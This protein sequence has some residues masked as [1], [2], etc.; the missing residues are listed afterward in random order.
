M[1]PSYQKGVQ[2]LEETASEAAFR[3]A[4]NFQDVESSLDSSF[5]SLHNIVPSPTQTPLTP[6]GSVPRQSKLSDGLTGLKK[7]LPPKAGQLIDN[8]GSYFGRSNP[9]AQAATPSK[10]SVWLFD[11]I[12]YRPVHVYPHREQPWHGHFVAGFFSKG[13]GKEAGRLVADIANKVGLHDMEIPDEEGE[14]RIAERIAPFLTT[15]KP[16]RFLDVIIPTPGDDQVHRLG[17]AGRS[18]VSKD[19]VG[20]LYE[21]ED[22]HVATVSAVYPR[23]TPLGPMSTFFTGPEG[24]TII[25]GGL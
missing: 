3:R 16:G 7:H 8:V 5:S 22:G 4:N 1:L 11:N 12:A 2:L 13:S 17:P 20:P 24:W 18:A 10:D 15:L 25:S 14:R 21:F 19:V 23:L 9:L 6:L